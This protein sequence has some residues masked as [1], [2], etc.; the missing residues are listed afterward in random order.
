MSEEIRNNLIK[1]LEFKEFQ[2][3]KSLRPNE[4]LILTTNINYW[5]KIKYYSSIHQKD[6]QQF[7]MCICEKSGKTFNFFSTNRMFIKSQLPIEELDEVPI[8][9]IKEEIKMYNL[10]IIKHIVIRIID[11]YI[12][13]LP[14][15]HIYEM[16]KLFNAYSKQ[17]SK[18]NTVNFDNKKI[19]KNYIKPIMYNLKKQYKEALYSLVKLD[20][21]TNI[22]I[23]YLIQPQNI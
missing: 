1:Y 3:L 22:I 2:V 7:S 16:N 5:F 18:N 20:D 9:I 21:L 11:R 4:I 12:L 15:T 19:H 13:Y 23:H 14:Y 17:C 8:K 10:E 6:N